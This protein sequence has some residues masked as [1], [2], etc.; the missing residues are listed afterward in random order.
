MADEIVS[1]RRGLCL[2]ALVAGLVLSVMAVRN[3]VIIEDAGKR[4]LLFPAAAVPLCC[5]WL[6]GRHSAVRV[7]R[8]GVVI[9]NFAVR[10]RIP[11]SEFSEF[12]VDDGLGVRLRDRRIID[13]V[14]FGGSVI[15][16]LLDYPHARKARRKLDAARDRVI[17]TGGESWPGGYEK[18]I[19]V[20]LV[21]LAAIIGACALLVLAAFVLRM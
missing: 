12:V 6:I 4:F 16:D 3:A 17:A 8:G 20:P 10:H 1:R 21:P 18:R 11:W 5:M 19:F 9:D 7:C 2:F 15:G 13:S 14:V